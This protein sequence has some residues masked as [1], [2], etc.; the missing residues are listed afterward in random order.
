MN[1]LNSID[2]D[3]MNFVQGNY[4]T[5]ILNI[6]KDLNNQTNTN[7]NNN[8]NETG[9]KIT[10]PK[11]SDLYISTKTQISYL[12]THVDLKE[13]FWKMPVIPY[14]S[15]KEG[16]IKKQM[17]F[18][19]QNKEEL[20]DITANI[21]E[22]K[23]KNIYVD[24]YIITNIDNPDG[25]V[26]FKDVRKIS[27]GIN[28]KDLISYR[29]KKKSAFYNCFVVIIRIKIDKI[30][31]DFHVKIF[32]TG[33]LEIPGIQHNS[34][35]SKILDI[36]VNTLN[37]LNIINEK[38]TYNNDSETVLINSNFNCGYLIN[39]DKLYDLLKNKYNINSS[40]DPCSYPGIQCNFFYDIRLDKQTGIQ[41][42]VD[43]SK[44]KKT[45]AKE[46]KAITNE[47]KR[48]FKVSFMIFRTGSVLVVGKCDDIMI[49]DIYLFIKDILSNEYDN[50]NVNNEIT[51]IDKQTKKNRVC[52][53]KKLKI[54][55]NYFNNNVNISG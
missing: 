25:R 10:A 41:P 1:D 29:C 5:N 31:K 16:I 48:I 55:T 33:K 47:N 42:M 14:Y 2:N 17:K 46:N 3:W 19:S 24:E 51:Y 44:D 26:K 18:N 38:I 49:N 9:D 36:L 40:Y 6:N 34:S 39:R 54:N 22:Y 45:I 12:S 53:K 7:T 8:N 21:Q 35:L 37:S 28:K 52:K 27:I 11:S 13:Y 30:F 50:I 32:N 4:N 15:E 20:K 23:N 43:K